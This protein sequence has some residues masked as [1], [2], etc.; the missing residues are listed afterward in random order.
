M[1]RRAYLFTSSA[2]SSCSALRSCDEP[3]V[4]AKRETLI[5]APKKAE[6]KS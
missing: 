3:I 5:E 4:K 2:N 6:L 1:R